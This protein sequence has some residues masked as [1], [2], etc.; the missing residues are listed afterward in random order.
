MSAGGIDLIGGFTSVTSELVARFLADTTDSD[1]TLDVTSVQAGVIRIGMTVTGTGIPASTTIQALGTGTG[2]NGTY[3]LSSTASATGTDVS[4]EARSFVSSEL[5]V[6]VNNAGA[7]ITGGLTVGSS[8]L[9]VETGK[10]FSDE[11]Y[12]Y[13]IKFAVTSARLGKCIFRWYWCDGW[14]ECS[15]C[16]PCDDRRFEYCR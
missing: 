5:G 7:K 1:N 6:A 4:C 14:I 13:S 15:G 12:S 8:G 2:S 11:P 9:V 3:T 10:P 16:G